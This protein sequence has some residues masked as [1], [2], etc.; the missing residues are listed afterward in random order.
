MTLSLGDIF[1]EQPA[2]PGSGVRHPY[3]VVQV[4]DASQ[5][6]IQTVLAC[7]LTT[8]LDRVS[9]PGNVLLEAG[10]ANLPRHSVVEVSKTAAI[11]MADLGEYIGAL[12]PARS[13]QIL[14]GMRFV[15]RSFLAR[16]AGDWS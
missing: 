11:P 1:W 3:V 2:A 5:G 4:G 16:T 8:N 9:L 10:E 14:A 7:A 12:S 6:G 13:A 15:Q